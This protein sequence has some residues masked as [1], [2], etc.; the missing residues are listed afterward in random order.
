MTKPLQNED[1][2]LSQSLQSDTIT[3]FTKCNNLPPPHCNFAKI[4]SSRQKFNWLNQNSITCAKIQLLVPKFSGFKIQQNTP[5]F[6]WWHQNSNYSTKYKMLILLFSHDSYHFLDTN[7]IES[8][9][10]IY[11]FVTYLGSSDNNVSEAPGNVLAVLGIIL[12]PFPAVEW[13]ESSIYSS[14]F[15]Q[16]MHHFNI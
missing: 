8:K 1:Y 7:C 5:K 12:L 14:I 15:K 3:F 4:A 2:R 6:N 16:V 11:K 13:T 10:V 9:N